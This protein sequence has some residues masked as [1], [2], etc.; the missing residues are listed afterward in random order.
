[1]KVCDEEVRQ[2]RGGGAGGGRFRLSKAVWGSGGA[3]RVTARATSGAA[4]GAAS[5]QQQMRQSGVA[6]CETGE[7]AASPQS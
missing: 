5:A 7:G 1:M 3:I 6:W 4:S 2:A